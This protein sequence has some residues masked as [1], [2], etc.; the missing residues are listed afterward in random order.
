MRHVVD[1]RFVDPSATTTKK[2]RVYLK[3]ADGC[4]PTLY[5]VGG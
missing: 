1:T 5:I 2:F 3:N 4:D